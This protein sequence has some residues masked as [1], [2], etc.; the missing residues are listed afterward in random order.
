M[1][2]VINILTHFII[3]RRDLLMQQLMSTG[4]SERSAFI[5]LY[6]ATNSAQSF[7]PSYVLPLQVENI[8]LRKL[9]KG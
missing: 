5:N 8:N 2:P 9:R 4:I 6:V 1:N 3:D 7:A